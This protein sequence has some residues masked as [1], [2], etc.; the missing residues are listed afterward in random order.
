MFNVFE[1]S[2]KDAKLRDRIIGQAREKFRIMDVDHNGALDDIEIHKLGDWVWQILLQSTSKDPWRE[3]EVLRAKLNRRIRRCPGEMMNFEEFQ[4]WLLNRF[5]DYERGKR[6]QIKVHMPRKKKKVKQLNK[7]SVEVKL[8]RGFSRTNSLVEL[9]EERKEIRKSTPVSNLNAKN[10]YIKR[11]AFGGTFYKSNLSTYLFTIS[12]ARRCDKT[13]AFADNRF[14]QLDTDN[15]FCLPK[16]KLLE[17]NE[18]VWK[19]F[20][21]LLADD[22]VQDIESLEDVEYRNEDLVQCIENLVDSSMD[23]DEYREWLVLQCKDFE[24]NRRAALLAKYKRKKNNQKSNRKNNGPSMYVGNPTHSGI[25]ASHSQLS[26]R[27]TR[28]ANRVGVTSKLK[29]IE[30]SH[31]EDLRVKEKEKESK[32]ISKGKEKEKEKDFFAMLK[33]YKLLHISKKKKLKDQRVELEFFDPHFH[34]WDVSE[35]GCHDLAHLFK[36]EVKVQSTSNY[37]RE[38]TVQS[39]TY[40]ISH[41]EEDQKQNHFNMTG[42]VFVE[43]MSVC[44]PDLAANQHNTLCFHEAVWA[45]KTGLVGGKNDNYYIVA[46]ASLEAITRKQMKQLSDI[47][48]V[49]G[50]RQIL[51][52][53]PSWPRNKALGIDLLDSQDFQNGFALLEKFNLS[54][55]LQCNPY[56]FL[57]A[58][59]LI[60]KYPKTVVIINHLGCPTMSDLTEPTRSK[61]YWSGMERLASYPNTYMK[62]SYLSY[63]DRDWENSKVVEETVHR[64]IHLFGHDRCM[65]ASNFPVEIQ[66]G[67]KAQVLFD[68]FRKLCDGRYTIPIQKKMFSQNAKHAYRINVEKEHLSFNWNGFEKSR[69]E[70]NLPLLVIKSIRTKGVA[71]CGYIDIETANKLGEVVAIFTGVSD[72][73]SFLSAEVKKVSNAAA[74]LG[75]KIGMKGFDALNRMR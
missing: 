2:P 43:A 74:A 49:R 40:T 55:D 1:L 35:T 65:F 70:L 26:P 22:N 19:Y 32:E 58:S 72:F 68:A 66:E 62:I 59:K 18:S 64:I 29:K 38:E 39:E 71:A 41:L 45:H 67:F 75:I 47:P 56:Q 30:T 12:E 5:I 14:N 23:F 31:V 33:E 50:I 73:N 57:K 34:V 24:K 36:P 46:S 48:K 21:S 42:G 8:G 9:V 13:V 44:F 16:V 17:L 61:L 15:E 63:I 4:G 60:E 54:F 7:S 37:A 69:I 3:R 10:P 20:K 52:F 51:N 11:V 25:Y 53:E 6:N 27:V 28:F